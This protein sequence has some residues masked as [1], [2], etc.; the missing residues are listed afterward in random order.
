MLNYHTELIWTINWL[1]FVI[2]LLLCSII[3]IHNML[4]EKIWRKRAKNLATIENNLRRL[5]Q[6]GPDAIQNICPA[7]L[8]KT[9][10]TQFLHIL[11]QRDNI[12]PKEFK[13][14]IKQCFITS[15]KITELERIAEKSCNKWRKIQALIGI[16]YAESPRALEILRSSLNDRNEDISY[17]SILALGQIKTRAS[18]KILLDFLAERTLGANRILSTLESFPPEIAEETIEKTYHNNAQVRFWTIKLL[19]K[20]KLPQSVNRVKELTL[21]VSDDVRA[22]SCE[23]LGNLDAKDAIAELLA[24]LKDK[25][26]YVRMHAVRSL[27]KIMGQEATEHIIPLLK[28]ESW[29]VRD[30]VE[31][32]LSASEKKV[33]GI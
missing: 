11:R 1:L 3:L 26:W 27:V 21:D 6:T 13:Q 15:G 10:N 32:V 20:L 24:R 12:L 8:R 29:L 7:I 9:D 18:A 28:D 4:R 19:G 31:K 30:T 14:N 16:G 5:A 25:I 17:F 23:C 2:C 33:K 22:A